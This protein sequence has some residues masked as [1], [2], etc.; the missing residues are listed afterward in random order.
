MLP[1]GGKLAPAGPAGN[2]GRVDRTGVPLTGAPPTGAPILNGVLVEGRKIT[3]FGQA[4]G[5]RIFSTIYVLLSKLEH[6]ERT[7]YQAHDVQF[8]SAKTGL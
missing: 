4:A 3:P 5:Q 1:L 2:M 6:S 7:D 8:H